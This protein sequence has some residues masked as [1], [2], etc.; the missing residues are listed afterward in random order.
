MKVTIVKKKGRKKKFQTRIAVRVTNE[1]HGIVNKLAKLLGC[2]Q[3]EAIRR[4]IIHL[5]HFLT[6]KHEN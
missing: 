6:N 2:D 5:Y 1:Q 3:G 4:A